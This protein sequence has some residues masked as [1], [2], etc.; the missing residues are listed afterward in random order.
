MNISVEMEN[1]ELVIRVPKDF[2]YATLVLNPQ[3][4]L[5]SIQDADDFPDHC[6]LEDFDKFSVDLLNE[7]RREDE[8]GWSSVND[9]IFKAGERAV[10]NGA[11]GV[12]FPEES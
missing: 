3:S 10:E 11:G 5:V 9:L 2:V 8:V 6:V 7:I 4:S 12:R 1:D